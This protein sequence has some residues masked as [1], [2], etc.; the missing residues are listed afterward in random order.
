M[1]DA[2]L[3]L[4]ELFK[5]FKRVQQIRFHEFKVQARKYL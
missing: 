2:T 1:G 3:R 4:Q 5:M